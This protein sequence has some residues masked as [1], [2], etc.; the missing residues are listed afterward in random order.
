VFRIS[1]AFQEKYGYP[2]FT[3]DIRRKVFGL[4]GAKMYRVDPNACRYQVN[5]GLIA[6]RRQLLNDRWGDRRH[7]LGN[8]HEIQTRRDFLQLWRERTANGEY[9]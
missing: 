8:R 7:A 9:A 2:E 4:T 3:D 1:D 5:R 6:S